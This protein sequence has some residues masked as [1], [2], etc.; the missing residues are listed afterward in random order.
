MAAKKKSYGL[1]K[2]SR[3]KFRLDPT[4]PLEQHEHESDRMFGY[5]QAYAAN[6]GLKLRELEPLMG[7]ALA[8]I[9]RYR[10]LYRWDERLKI[11]AREAKPEHT[12]LADPRNQL[13]DPPPPIAHGLIAFALEYL[14]AIAPDFQLD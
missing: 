14:P 11:A 12:K 1:Q 13:N 2:R 3:E 9:S 5:F 7:V 10:K 4:K 6:P 8:S